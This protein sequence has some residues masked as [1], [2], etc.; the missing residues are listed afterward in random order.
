VNQASR[1]GRGLL[2]V[3]RPG[4]GNAGL[5]SAAAPGR[6]P[7]DQTIGAIEVLATTKQ[8]AGCNSVVNSLLTHSIFLLADWGNDI[9]NVAI[10][11][12]RA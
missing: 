10:T 6:A 12:P 5:L 4:V 11:L 8:S 3:R 2:L 1:P 7:A 9:R